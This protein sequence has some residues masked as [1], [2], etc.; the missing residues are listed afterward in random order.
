M[1]ERRVS[2]RGVVTASGVAVA[3]S[4]AGC[5]EER[6]GTDDPHLGEPEPFVGVDLRTP[7]APGG[8]HV[9]PPVVHLVDGGTVE[10]TA[11]AGTHDVATYHPRTHGEQP[12]IPESAEPWTS[13]RLST[14]ESFDRRFERE[15]VYDYV[16]RPHERRGAVGSVVVGWPE[17]Q[18]EPALDPPA[19]DYPDAARDALGRHNERIRDVLEDVHA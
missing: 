17:P 3:T 5:L 13:E 11:L 14:D 4:V 16:C 15:G 7:S 8:E 2:R 6:P 10:W 1:C 19:D 9:E 12:R 18:A